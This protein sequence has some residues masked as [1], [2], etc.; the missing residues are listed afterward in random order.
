MTFN[1]IAG[2]EALL[3]FF[4]IHI[5]KLFRSYPLTRIFSFNYSAHAW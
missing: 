5:W 1:S 3:I 4:L 2:S